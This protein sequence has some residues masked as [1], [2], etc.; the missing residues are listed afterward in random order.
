M[1]YDIAIIG[2]GPGGVSAAITSK[3]RNKNIIIFGSKEL[4]NKISNSEEINNYPGFP[5]IKGKDLK[6]ALKL[7]LDALN[8]EITEDKIT[9]VYA[10]GD[11]FFIQG[12]DSYEATSVILACGVTSG[13]TI[14]GESSLVGNGV[15]YCATCDAM[16]YKNKEVAVI[17]YNTESIEEAEFLA[18]VCS[19]VYFIPMKITNLN[20]KNEKIE[21]VNKAPQEIKAQ[22]RKR[23]IEFNNE[24]SL[25]VD[26]VFVLRDAISPGTLV[27]GLDTDGAN[28]VCNKDMSTNIPGCF[29]CGDI[30]GLPYQYIKAAGEG[31]I[32]ALSAVKYIS[33]KK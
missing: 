29:V 28:V 27:P 3:I 17:G 20:F 24:D 2:T 32:A 23:I 18:E 19:K 5:K 1:R 14:E 7:H 16:L 8:I 33:T 30:A 26:G 4:S 9:S 13:K 15:S 31:N 25:I 10:M 22:L 21:I 11:Y 12:K 6:D